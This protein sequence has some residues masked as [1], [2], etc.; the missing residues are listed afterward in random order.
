MKFGASVWPF[1][2]EAPYEDTI[3]R[4]AKL[5]F[6]AVELIAWDRKVLDEYYTPGKIKELKDIIA[7]EGMEL[8][9][10]VS[11][12]SLMA[13]PVVRE[14]KEALEHFKKLVEVGSE[15]GAKIV[16]SVAPYPFSMDFPP[17]TER[18]LVQEQII[19]IPGNLDWSKN[20]EDYIEALR[21]CASICEDAGIRYSL[22][23]H[24]YRY[25]S[26]AD[27]M[28]RILSEVESPAMGI[29]FDP[30]H[31]FPCGEIPQVVIYRLG[32]N[33]I[34][35]HLSDNDGLTNA[36]WRP[37]KGKMDWQGILKA[38]KDVGYSGVLSLE[39]ED[40]PGVSRSAIFGEAERIST[41]LL[42]A[43]YIKAREYLREICQHL[44]IP[45]E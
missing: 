22:E 23:P 20:W 15:L 9:Q 44:N 8:S 36:H 26:N 10:F 31:L 25:V 37:G 4:I 12:P 34:H 40:V 17:I 41:E 28:L 21:E 42:D 14:R 6:R 32:K 27:S 3:V 11:T 1:K 29:N 13:S 16:N 7:S 38:F 18:P 19:D 45:V 30:S 35:A 5:G 24:P 33:I 39:L 43:E 2:W